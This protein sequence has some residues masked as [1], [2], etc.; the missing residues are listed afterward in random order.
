[1]SLAAYLFV[2]E[3][4]KVFRELVNNTIPDPWITVIMIIGFVYI[5][6]N[7]GR[8]IDID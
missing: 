6:Q 8:I 7:M 4:N 3:F 2:I 5:A 1:M